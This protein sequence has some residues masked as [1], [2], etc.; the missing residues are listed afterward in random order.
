CAQSGAGMAVC[1]SLAHTTTT[2]RFGTGIVN[3]YGR[4][5]VELS[6]SACYL[7]EISGGR[8]TLGLG[9]SHQPFNEA[10]GVEPGKPVPDMRNYLERLR[11]AAEQFGGLPPVYLAALRTRMAALA[12]KTAGGALF[13]NMP[14]SRIEET[15][16]PIPRA[17]RDAGFWVGNI[18]PICVAEDRAAAIAA[19]KR[20]ELIYVAL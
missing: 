17:R 8:F 5:P 3:I 13:A 7:N 14:F 9:V 6:Q 2:L 1:H 12:G 20:R 19:M 18:V 15:T 16:A 10:L 11:G 4:N